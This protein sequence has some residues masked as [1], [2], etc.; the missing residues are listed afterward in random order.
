MPLCENF[1]AP[2]ANKRFQFAPSYSVLFKFGS[3]TSK[4][5]NEIWQ[6][7]IGVN[8]GALDFNT[9]AVPEFSTAL[10][11]TFLKDYFSFG[12]GYNFGA[13][14][15]YFMVGFRIPVGTLPLPMFNN[16]ESTEGLD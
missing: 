5:I 11:F 1:I 7:S 16:I 4:A 9:D 15:D 3:R 10:E 12:Y 8:F 2:C 14:A 13:D 6:P